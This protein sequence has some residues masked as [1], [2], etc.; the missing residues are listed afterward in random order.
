MLILETF[1][2]LIIMLIMCIPIH[3]CLKDKTKDDVTKIQ[4]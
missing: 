3:Y 4:D 2:Y 1:A